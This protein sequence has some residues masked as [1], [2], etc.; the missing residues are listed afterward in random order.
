MSES[1]H[2]VCPHCGGINRVPASRLDGGGTCGRCKQPL[3]TGEPLE[4]DEVAFERQRSHSQIP[5]L[6]DFWASWCGP[7]QMMAPAFAEAAVRLE[8]RMRLLKVN[9]ELAQGLSM[10]YGIRSIPTM[11]LIANGAEVGR[12]SGALD[13][14]GIVRWANQHL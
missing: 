13:A 7:C 11:M 8:P 6:V 4:V 10:R 9:T 12:M 1:L 3:F 2:V 14:A 5:L